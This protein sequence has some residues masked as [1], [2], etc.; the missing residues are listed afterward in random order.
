MSDVAARERER[1]NKEIEDH[2]EREKLVEGGEL[3]GHIREAI[4][5]DLPDEVPPA[6]TSTCTACRSRAR[7]RR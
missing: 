2:K 5:C 1:R 6:K 7:A 4:H 3:P